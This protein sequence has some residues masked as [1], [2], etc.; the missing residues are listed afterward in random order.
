MC[1]IAAVG[2]PSSEV[3]TVAPN[4]VHPKSEWTAG[5]D[6]AFDQRYDVALQATAMGSCKLLNFA[7][8]CRNIELFVHTSSGSAKRYSRE[9]RF[10]EEKEC[11]SPTDSM[12]RQVC[13]LSVTTVLEKETK[14]ASDYKKLVKPNEVVPKMKRLG[15]I[16]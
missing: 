1:V 6:T 7:S 13:V 2:G 10:M 3:N 9:G 16:R 5:G 12:G 4:S 8:K 15:L 14:W 11:F